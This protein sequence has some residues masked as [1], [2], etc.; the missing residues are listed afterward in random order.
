MD[1]AHVEV[2]RLVT[3]SVPQPGNV[4]VSG[5]GAVLLRTIVMIRPHLTLLLTQMLEGVA[6]VMVLLVM[7]LVRVKT[8]AAASGVIAELETSIAQ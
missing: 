5:D 1:Q 3:E 2:V 6:Q 7:K 8:N 4:A